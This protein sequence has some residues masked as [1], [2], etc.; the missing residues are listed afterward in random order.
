MNT[1][2]KFGAIALSAALLAACGSNNSPTPVVQDAQFEVRLVNLTN[3]QAM[4]PVAMIMHNTGF[5]NFVD[6]ETA[7]SNGTHCIGLNHWP[8]STGNK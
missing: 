4:S 8:C 6:G 7:S 1:K 5:N 2:I 3:G